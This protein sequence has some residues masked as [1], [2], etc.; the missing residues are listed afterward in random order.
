MTPTDPRAVSQ[1]EKSARATLAISSKVKS[2]AQ[3]SGVVHS[4]VAAQSY[5]TER[6]REEM[7]MKGS[8]PWFHYRLNGNG[9]G[10]DT[11]R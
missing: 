10:I 9:V 3:G 4:F 6:E 11:Y 1:I 2:R 5:F 8:C 7:Q